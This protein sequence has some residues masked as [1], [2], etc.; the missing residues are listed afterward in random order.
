M[1]D[2]MRRLA[3]TLFPGGHPQ[4]QSAGRA[5]SAQL[6]NRISAEAAARIYASTKYLAHTAQD[7][8]KSRVVD[9]IVKQGMGQIT[10]ADAEALYDGHIS[11]A[12][13]QRNADQ[14]MDTEDDTIFIDASLAGR[15]Y[16]LR[17]RTRTISIDAP[18]FTALL[19][20]V[21]SNGWRGAANLFH[22]NGNALTVLSGTYA[23]SDNDAHELADNL[24]TLIRLQGL[25]GD[26]DPMEIMGPL[27][28]IASEGAFS[29]H[30]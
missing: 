26:E 27:I 6:G 19:L 9:Y 21:R 17:N 24:K 1:R 29:V 2:E 28:A 16:Q 7:K 5:I 10:Q 11:S 25:E 8:S 13:D 14:T 18:T 22:P 23:I 15:E 4:I 20:G 12:S 30:A 3:P